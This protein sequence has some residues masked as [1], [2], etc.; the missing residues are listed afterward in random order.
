MAAKNNITIPTTADEEA[1]LTL[2]Q[3]ADATVASVDQL[4][5]Y[6]DPRLHPVPVV[7]GVRKYWKA[8][9]NSLN[10]WSHR[11]NLVAEKP[12]STVLQGRSI[13]IKDNMSVGSLPLTVGTFSQLT[14]PDGKY[15]ISPIDASIVSRVLEAGATIIGTSTCENYSCTPLS[16]TSASGPVHNPWLF[17]RTV[18]GSSSGNSAMLS[19]GLARKAGVPGLD[20]AG[21]RVEIALGGDQGGSIRLPASFTGIYGLK[22]T[23]GLVPCESMTRFVI[24]GL[25]CD[26][27]PSVPRKV[28]LRP[29]WNNAYFES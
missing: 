7:G 18:G 29:F 27:R 2:L 22:P 1:Y 6:V 19:L 28:I 11:T 13:A 16:Y 24:S 23:F 8:E 25:E 17:G 10:G 5:D 3:S 15:P 21:D 4:P 26:I 14:G 20:S 12:S 9:E